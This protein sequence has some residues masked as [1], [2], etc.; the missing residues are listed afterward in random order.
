MFVRL[1]ALTGVSSRKIRSG[2]SS[3]AAK[4]I[5]RSS[6]TKNPKG[7]SSSG[8]LACG[9][10]MPDPTPVEPAALIEQRPKNYIGV[11]IQLEPPSGKLLEALARGSGPATAW[12]NTT[13]LMSIEKR[14][15]ED[16]FC[17]GLIGAGGADIPRPVR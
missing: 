8:I 3:T 14:S 6:R 4:S 9:R 12:R 2:R 16:C 7:R 13:S 1:F 17:T 11:Q 10:A 15:Q 5:G